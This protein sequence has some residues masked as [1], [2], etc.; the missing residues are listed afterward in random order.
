MARFMIAHL[1]EGRYGDVGILKEASTRLM[2]ERHFSHHPRLPGM[3]H[4]FFESYLNGRRII[5]HEGDTFL[6][7]SGLYLLPGE[8]IGIFVSYNSPT[9]SL[10]RNALLPLFM[11]YYFPGEHN[12]AP[13]LPAN[14]RERARLYQGEFH[15]SRTNYTTVEKRMALLTSVRAG[16]DDTGRL[17]LT[18][19]GETKRYVEI[20]PGLLQTLE[21]EELI[22]ARFD[23]AGRA[24]HLLTEG[25]FVFIRT[26]WY[27]GVHFTAQF[28]ALSALLWFGTLA[29]W[30]VGLFRA[31]KKK[32]L[33][34]YLARLAAGLF[35]IV[36]MLF[37]FFLAAALGA[38][39]PVYNV[40]GVFLG[41]TPLMK[42]LLAV[43]LS[44][45][46]LGAAMLVCTVLVWWKGCWEFGARI[47]YTLLTLIAA[48]LLTGLHYWNIL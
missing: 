9:A 4:G 24:S 23:Q 26:P 30:I 38:I 6:F 12:E 3:A 2:H 11:D 36:F 10:A 44:L 20:E 35:G 32:S 47:H 16:M 31:R 8:N 27:A 33:L 19:G 29:G 1:Q 34:T 21:G 37:L 45:V 46:I 41:L 17:L 15:L 39:D 18:A 48:V 43:P 13:P 25:P 40:P 22:A 7:H 42:G 14:A 28:L 5:F